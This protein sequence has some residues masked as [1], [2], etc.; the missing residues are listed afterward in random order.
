MA[1]VLCFFGCVITWPILFPVNATGGGGQAQ[2]DVLSYANINQQTEYNRYYAHA[3]VA[4]LYFGFVMYMIMREC[5]FYI[6]LRQAFLLS[7]FYSERISSRTVLFTAVPEPLRNEASLR[8]VFGPSVK[9]IW[10]TSD[11][12]EV[13][14]LVEER[15]KVA[16]RLEKAEVDLIKLANKLRREA[17]KNGSSGDTSALVADGESGSLAA[18]WVPPEKRPTH[19]LGLFGLYGDKVDSI[20]W[21]RRELE[22]L[23]PA[24]EAAQQ[25]Y[26]AGGYKKIASVFIE[27]KT[28]S[29]AEGASQ[30]LAHHLGLHMTPRYVGV[31]PGE[32]IWSSLRIP[33]WQI[34]I[35]RY[36]VLGFISAMILF[37][38]VP[39]AFV[40][41]VSNIETLASIS[42]LAWLKDIPSAILGIITGLLPSV[43]LSLLMSLVPIIIR[44]KSSRSLPLSGPL[45]LTHNVSLRQVCWRALRFSSR[46]LHPKCLLCVPGHS[47]LP[48]RHGCFFGHRCRQASLRQAQRGS[49]HPG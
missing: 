23:V 35:R 46:A 14:E 43:M 30:I 11:S 26:R 39:V 47:G 21:C 28:Q 32:V 10:I 20:D 17:I 4:W 5:I 48:R 8:K 13:D 45:L 3:L 31:R 33:W 12:E 16:M 37:W 2:L 36:M 9:R 34:V 15:D 29:D 1:F 38:A 42:W 25:K 7:P 27:F 40:G 44:R 22:R 24:A 49:V 6:N 41:A 19:R 18:R